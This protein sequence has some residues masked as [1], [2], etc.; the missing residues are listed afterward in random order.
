MRALILGITGQDGSYLTELLLKKGYEVHGLYRKTATGNTKNI[1][2]LGSQINLHY[3]DITDFDSLEKVI[4]N[5]SPDELYNEA[6]LDSA[7]VSFENPLYCYEVTALGVGRICEI[8]RR[9]NPTIKYFQPLSSHMFGESMNVLTPQSLYSP[10]SPYA[11]AKVFAFEII[12]FYRKTYDLR[13]YGGILTNHTSPR[14]GEDYLFPK[15]INSIKRIKAGIQTK[16]K[17]GNIDINLDIGWAPEYMRIVWDELQKEPHDFCVGTGRPYQIKE[18]LES[19]FSR[20]KLD[21]EKYVEFESGLQ[22]FWENGALFTEKIAKI[23]GFQVLEK[24][25]NEDI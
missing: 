3:G 5:V 1:N 18:Y 10:R 15:I 20:A 14:Q 16:L 11:V 2:H 23:D 7:A 24:L 6:D 12:K 22:R 4:S 8:I 9:I 13:I 19:A 25:Y 17:M 21:W